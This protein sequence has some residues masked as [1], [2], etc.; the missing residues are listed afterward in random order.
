[1]RYNGFVDLRKL[2]K[3][4][5]WTAL[6]LGVVGG[7]LRWLVV[8][9]WVVP[10]DD[11]VLS[12]SIAPSLS[13]GDIVLLFHAKRPG[14][15]ELVRCVD[16]DEPR[17]FI[18]GRIAAEGGD[19]LVIEGGR[20]KINGNY[21]SIEHGCAEPT[22]VVNDPNTGSPVEMRCDV[23]E[24]GSVAHKRGNRALEGISEPEPIQRTIQNGFVFLV[25][26]NRFYP[27]DS[28]VYGPIDLATCD[29]RIIF[30][31][32]GTQG[33]ADEKTRFTWIN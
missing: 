9:V 21:A 30:R 10:A 29:A 22:F 24:L 15:G 7:L 27:L 6:L 8:K 31:I 18:I 5:L 25:S 16:P 19:T 2:A 12:A 13:P 1:M 4:L 3:G 28:R 20:L 33:F 32:W 14:F 23:E 17:R 11:P 26:D